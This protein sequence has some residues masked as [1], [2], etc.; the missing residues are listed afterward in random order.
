MYKNE[1]K[2]NSIENAFKYANKFCNKYP[3]WRVIN[4]IE[5]VS[6]CNGLQY[7]F[8]SDKG[9]FHKKV[10]KIPKN[11]KYIMIAIA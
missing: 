3:T 6:N 2:E 1:I 10:D 11:D 7:G 5:D 8:I 9:K 4:N